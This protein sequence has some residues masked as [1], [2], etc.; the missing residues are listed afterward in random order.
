MSIGLL[1]RF[2]RFRELG[3]A[4]PNTRTVRPLNCM[5]TWSLLCQTSPSW[6]ILRQV[7]SISRRPVKCYT[8]P[9][10]MCNVATYAHVGTVCGAGK[11]GRSGYSRTLTSGRYLQG[12]DYPTGTAKPKS[13]QSHNMVSTSDSVR[14]TGCSYLQYS[15]IAFTT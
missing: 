5:H 15:N 12:L 2:G 8:I 1:R 7:A 14:S 13:H 3:W 6:S 4:L 11:H 10:G 9:S